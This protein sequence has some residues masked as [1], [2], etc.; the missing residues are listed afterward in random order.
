MSGARRGDLNC[1][2]C[3][4]QLRLSRKVD[5]CKPLPVAS[6]GFLDL[7]CPPAVVQLE[8]RLTLLDPPVLRSLVPPPPLGAFP[9]L[10]PLPPRPPPPPNPPLPLPLP[11]PPKPLPPP[12]P[13]L[14]PPPKPLLSPLSPLP[15][16]LPP[17][18]LPPPRPPGPSRAPPLPRA[19]AP[20]AAAP[21]P[22]SSPVLNRP[23]PPRV[24]FISTASSSRTSRFA[25]L[26][27]AAFRSSRCCCFRILMI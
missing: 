9:G 26:S 8:R 18:P 27:S 14:P 15:P 10:N 11:P 23:F 3:Q 20:G 13:P 1:V 5:E 2:L 24:F 22:L 12:L 25:A 19:P 7:P 4:K 16:P 17:P 6:R 21:A